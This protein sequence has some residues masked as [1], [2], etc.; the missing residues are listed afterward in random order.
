M[1]PFRK[2]CLLT[3]VTTFS[4]SQIRFCHLGISKILAKEKRRQSDIR[5]LKFAMLEARIASLD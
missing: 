5:F 4:N 3:L 1:V 2:I